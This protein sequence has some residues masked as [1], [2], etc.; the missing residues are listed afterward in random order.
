M[1]QSATAG[2]MR[3]INRSAILELI[4]QSSPIAR[5]Q[6]ARRLNM[7]LP[8]VMRIIDQLIDED[9]VRSSG[10]TERSGGRRRPLLEFN[11]NAY[12][13][14]GVDL[15]GSKMFGTVADLAGTIQHEI[16]LPHADHQGPD[17]PIERLRELIQRLLDAP[18]P[19]GQRIWGIG[20]GAPGITLNPEGVVAWAP[21]FGWRNLPLKEILTDSFDLPVFVENDVNLATLG[22]WGFGAGRGVRNLVCISVGT[23]IGAGIILG[24]TLYRGHNQ[25]AGEIGYLLPGVEFLGRRYDHFGALEGLASGSGVA[26]R[27]RQLLEQEGLVVSSEF[28]AHDVFAAARRR[29]PWAEQVV[30]ETVR[31]LGLAIANISSLLNPELVVLEGGVARSA[32]LLIEPIRRCLDGVTLYIPRLAASSL[33]RRA[34]A[35]GAVMLVLTGTMEHVVVK[36]LS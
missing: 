2:L 8:T 20:V 33:G 4:R 28:S 6:I 34:T 1:E 13:V 27:A 19:A 31:Y 24:G 12:A 7:S 14:I 11:G 21:S 18:R 17:D 3:S 26:E 35:L 36:R 30:D 32:D 29:E 9:L 5:S 10:Q 15:G 16:Y 22:E 23:G 25:A